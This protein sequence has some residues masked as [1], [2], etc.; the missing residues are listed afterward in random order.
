MTEF[1]HVTNGEDGGC[2]SVLKEV[3]IEYKAI[4]DKLERGKGKGE[5]GAEQAYLA[6]GRDCKERS[7]RSQGQGRGLGGGRGRSSSRGRCGRGFR[8]RGGRG[9]RTEGSGGIEENKGN[10][11]GGAGGGGS[12]EYKFPGRCFRCGHRGHQMIDCTTSEKDC[13]PWCERCEGWGHTKDKC[14]T[15]EAVLA[16]VVEQES[17]EDSVEAFSTTPT[18]IN[19]YH[20]AH[21]HAHEKLLR[22]T[23]K[24]QGVQLTDGP[25]LPCL[26]CSMYKGQ[27]LPLADD[28]EGGEGESRAEASRQGGDF[29]RGSENPADDDSSSSS[30]SSESSR[31]GE[32]RGS[33]NG[34]SDFT[35]PGG[36]GGSGRDEPGDP[37][38][39]GSSG[40]SE[41]LEELK[42][43]PTDDRYPSGREG[44]KLLW[45]ASNAGLLHFGLERGR[46]RKQTRQTSAEE[47]QDPVDT[48]DPEEALLANIVETGGVE[49]VEEY[50]CNS[51]VKEQWEEEQTRRME[52]MCRRELQ[53]VLG[54]E[55]QAFGA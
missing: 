29:G 38:G 54:T 37:G 25:L 20:L 15:E 50:I 17:D 46:T 52:E 53:K 40:N 41:N 21:G 43:D 9:S 36:A 48:P 18:D 39:D 26:G 45:N 47:A 27:L 24:Q 22:I 35:D 51:L 28:A 3:M 55:Q 34:G 2:Q 16:Q 5:K 30:S 12:G 49:I 10:S 7:S 6:T 19:D 14:P 23:A 8:G 33:S 13:V 1:G 11:S 42:Y 31:A 4:R 44:K 32:G